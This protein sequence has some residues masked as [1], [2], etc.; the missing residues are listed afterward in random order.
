MK[1]LIYK[2][3]VWSIIIQIITFFIGLYALLIK[4]PF[5]LTFI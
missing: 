2:S 5:S 4:T 1:N 3:G